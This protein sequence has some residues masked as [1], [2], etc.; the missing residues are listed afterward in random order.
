MCWHPHAQ[1]TPSPTRTQPTWNNSSS[2]R[3]TDRQ[4]LNARAHTHLLANDDA[5]LLRGHVQ[6]ER[7]LLPQPLSWV[8]DVGGDGAHAQRPHQCS[9]LLTHIPT[10][11]PT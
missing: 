5:D 6:E 3:Q 10:Y 9:P 7:E 8:R 11:L 1:S 2:H 4:T